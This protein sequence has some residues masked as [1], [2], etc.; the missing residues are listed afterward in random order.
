MSIIKGAENQNQHQKSQEKKY[1]TVR[2]KR[3]RL[4]YYYVVEKLK[5]KTED[6][7]QY[8]FYFM[9]RMYCIMCKLSMY[10]T[11]LYIL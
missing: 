3:M 10:C 7:I 2:R 8:E 11:I 4:E 5:L 9:C 1:S 6:V